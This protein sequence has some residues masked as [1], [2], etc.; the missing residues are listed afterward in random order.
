MKLTVIKIISCTGGF[1]IRFGS[2]VLGSPAQKP[3]GWSRQE[4][5]QNQVKSTGA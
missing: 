1:L 3:K 2:F 5:K 4:T